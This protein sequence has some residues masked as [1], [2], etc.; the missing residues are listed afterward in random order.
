MGYNQQRN[1][2]G[3]IHSEVHACSRAFRYSSTHKNDKKTKQRKK[4]NIVI[5]R[6]SNSKNILAR[7]E[8]CWH[9]VQHMKKFRD[10]I[11]RVYYS[12]EN[13]NI[14]GYC[15]LTQLIKEDRQYYSCANRINGSKIS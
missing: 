1:K 7:S 14:I 15:S 8:P 13:S 3:L 4:Y 10:K 5:L 2:G 11:D 6:F 12:T 9:C